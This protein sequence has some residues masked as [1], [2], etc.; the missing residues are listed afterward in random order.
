MLLLLEK[1]RFSSLAFI[2]F[3]FISDTQ[4][5]YIGCYVDIIKNRALP[6]EKSFDADNSP[7]KCNGHCLS[8]GFPLFGVQV[9]Q[10]FAQVA[11]IPN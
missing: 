4:H 6:Q 8:Q 1:N 11:Y 10:L 5:P 3:Y 7:W 2:L 9:S